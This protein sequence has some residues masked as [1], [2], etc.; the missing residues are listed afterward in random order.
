MKM[1]LLCLLAGLLSACAPTPDIPTTYPIQDDFITVVAENVNLGNQIIYQNE[2]LDHYRM[3]GV[4][5][6]C[7]K[8]SSTNLGSYRC[9][10]VDGEFLTK[11]LN[12]V[13]SKWEPLETPVKI[14]RKLF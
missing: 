13:T 7:L 2:K 12:P 10:A 4:D 9:F 3:D 5:A 8:A 6:Y 14:I 11:G 1:V